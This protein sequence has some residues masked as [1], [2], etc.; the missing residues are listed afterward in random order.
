MNI[1]AQVRFDPLLY[2]GWAILS[3]DLKYFVEKKVQGFEEKLTGD[4]KFDYKIKFQWHFKVKS[5]FLN[6]N[7]Y[8]WLWKWKEYKNHV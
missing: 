1:K 3:V 2:A 5:I 7:P 8:F 4:L 6:M